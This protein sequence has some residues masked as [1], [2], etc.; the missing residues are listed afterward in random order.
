MTL[1]SQRPQGC[2]PE[3]M[4]VVARPANPSGCQAAHVAW[5]AHGSIKAFSKHKCFDATTFFVPLIRLL[6]RKS[7]RHIRMSRMSARRNACTSLASYID[8][9]PLSTYVP[10]FKPMS[11]PA[12]LAAGLRSV[13]SDHGKK[14]GCSGLK[15]GLLRLACTFALVRG[16]PQHCRVCVSEAWQNA[17]ERCETSTYKDMKCHVTAALPSCCASCSW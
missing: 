3:R 2:E 7:Q 1:V 12:G 6:Q 11:S 10:D 9:S 5:T 16:D 17:H 14:I 15:L 8:L 4:P 13:Q